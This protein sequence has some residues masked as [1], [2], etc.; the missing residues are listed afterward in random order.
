MF[1][2][3]PFDRPPLD[4][5]RLSIFFPCW[6]EAGH[7]ELM[8]DAALAVGGQLTANADHGAEDNLEILIID[9]GSTDDTPRIAQR[10]A[11]RHPAVRHIRHPRN[12]GYGSA[13]ST[14]FT[15]ARMPWVFYT[16][17]DQ[18]FELDELP[19]LID[20]LRAEP[21]THIISGYRAPRRDPWPRVIAGK[22][23][24]ALANALFDMHLRDVDGAFKIYPRALFDHIAMRSTGAL[25]DAEI[26]AR[27]TMLGCTIAQCPVTHLPRT[28]GSA[29]GLAPRTVYRGLR[30]VAMLT[31]DIMAGPMGG[32]RDDAHTARN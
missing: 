26:L 4:P 23:W 3:P 2:R 19:R 12:L 25:I 24:T 30:E 27:A 18:Q 13:L 9:D 6:N 31:D 17:G 11:D 28:S 21:T 7:L 32:H 16:D 15:T 5:L 29:T 1:S 8:V 14:G 22:C 20:L 10:L